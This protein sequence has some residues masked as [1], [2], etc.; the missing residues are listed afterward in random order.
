MKSLNHDT[1]HSFVT[2]VTT[3]MADSKYAHGSMLLAIVTAKQHKKRTV[4]VRR[5]LQQ[6]TYMSSTR[7]VSN[8][9]V[10]HL[11]LKLTGQ[12]IS[13]CHHHQHHH[14]A[15]TAEVRCDDSP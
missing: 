3:K 7:Q 6:I 1:R 13:G 8:L 10:V 4:W 14:D 9:L 11:F 12:H 5:W 2:T 15:K